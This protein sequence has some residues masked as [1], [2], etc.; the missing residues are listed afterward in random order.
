MRAHPQRLTLLILASGLVLGAL[1]GE[2]DGQLTSAPPIGGQSSTSA[3]AVPGLMPAAPAVKGRYLD[4]VPSV[5]WGSGSA[6]DRLTLIVDVTPKP[7]M[8]VYAPG[9]KGYTPV[10]LTIDAAGDYTVAPTQYPKPSM[11]FFAPLNERVQVFDRVFRLSREVI[12]R[13]ARP[14]ARTMTG[15]LE[16][17]AC[18]DKVCYLPQTLSLSWMVTP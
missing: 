16:Y 14:S 18:D 5:A 1:V 13:G 6:R 12:G 8:R 17:Q 11:Y 9:N 7:G 4:A 15:R 10:Q 2:A 3:A